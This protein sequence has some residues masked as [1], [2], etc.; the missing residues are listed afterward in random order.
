MQLKGQMSTNKYVAPLTIKWDIFERP[1]NDLT[2]LHHQKNGGGEL[3][4]CSPSIPRYERFFLTKC[5]LQLVKMGIDNIICK[6]EKYINNIY[7][8]SAFTDWLSR[9]HDISKGQISQLGG[10]FFGDVNHLVCRSR[11]LYVL[12]SSFRIKPQSGRWYYC[13]KNELRNCEILGSSVP[14]VT[15][16]T[17]RERMVQ[18]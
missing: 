11:S 17:R 2:F 6:L 15:T 14:F 1:L 5:N 8:C 18:L 9:M 16:S 7:S 12:H 10:T 13:E 3:A 4:L